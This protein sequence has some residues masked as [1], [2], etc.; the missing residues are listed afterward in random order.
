MLCGA[1]ATPLLELQPR[2]AYRALRSRKGLKM[3]IRSKAQE[4]FIS[5]CRSLRDLVPPHD[6]KC[7]SAGLPL[8]RLH[9]GCADIAFGDIRVG[10]SPS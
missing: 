6:R 9:C 10:P 7:H 5:I 8:T 2:G 4:H 1:V 3:Q